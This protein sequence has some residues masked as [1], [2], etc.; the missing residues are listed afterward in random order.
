MNMPIYKHLLAILFLLTWDL[1][2][3]AQQAAVVVAAGISQQAAV[4]VPPGIY[5]ISTPIVLC[6]LPKGAIY[7]ASAATIVA[8]APMDAMVTICSQSEN[9]YATFK[10]GI[11]DANHLATTGLYVTATNDSRI[12][13]AAIQNAT[14]NGVV[15]DQT[16]DV[17]V[18][19]NF[20]ELGAIRFNTHNG[21]VLNS[22]PGGVLGVQ[23]NHIRVGQIFE[24]GDSGV[25]VFGVSSYNYLEV[26]P[27]EHNAMYG[28]FDGAGHNNWLVVNANSNAFRGAC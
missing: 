11:L 17:G 9:L 24:N 19:N 21:L 3:G 16:G 28:C 27:V 8:D 4:V 7:D 26:G 6:D 25:A 2:A 15:I 5:R 1:P 22:P 20:I 23:G 14:V 10:F 13:V 18:F 12:D